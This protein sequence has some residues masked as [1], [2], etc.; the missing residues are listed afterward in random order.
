MLRGKALDA[1]FS[2]GAGFVGALEEDEGFSDLVRL[3][4]FG[5]VRAT[6]GDGSLFGGEEEGILTDLT[7]EL[8]FAAVV[9][10]EEIGGGIAPDTADG[11]G[12]MSGVFS[13]F[14]LF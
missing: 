8:P 10:V 6:I 3:K 2:V 1:L 7:E 14:D 5:A 11:R 13:A 4:D 12:N 9:A